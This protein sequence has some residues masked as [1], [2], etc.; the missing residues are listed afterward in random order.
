MP[1]NA[2]VIPACDPSTRPRSVATASGEAGADTLQGAAGLVPPSVSPPVPPPPVPTPGSPPSSGAR[3]GTLELQAASQPARISGVIVNAR[4]VASGGAMGGRV[5]FLQ[6]L[7]AESPISG[8]GKG[9]A[10]R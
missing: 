2:T 9:G 1:R 10:R 6:W 3:P 7:A 5:G 4:I 8:A